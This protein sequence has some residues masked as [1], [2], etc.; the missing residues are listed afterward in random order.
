MLRFLVKPTFD[1][2][3]R[4]AQQRYKRLQNLSIPYKQ[5]SVYLHQWVIKN[6]ET[7]GGNVGRWPPFSPVTLAIIERTDPSRMPA[8]LLQKTGALRQSFVP[9]ASSRN[10]GVGSELPYSKDHH[11]GEGRLPERRLLPRKPE[12]MPDIRRIL[13]NHVR[14]TLFDRP[15]VT[16][17]NK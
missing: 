8:K 3:R 1:A 17:T 16:R 5:A 10:A 4:S 14:Q 11:E 15:W 13:Q 2:V 7:E 9:F 6:I 12:V